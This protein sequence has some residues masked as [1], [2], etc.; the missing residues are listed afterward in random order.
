MQKEDGGQCP[1]MSIFS[2]SS[3]CH[4]ARRQE[5][6]GLA[7]QTCTTALEVKAPRHFTLKASGNSRDELIPMGM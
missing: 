1:W 6:L 7:R 4:F 2:I 5:F 3:F